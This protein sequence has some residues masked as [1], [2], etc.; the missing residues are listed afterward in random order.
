MKLS[1][2]PVERYFE[3]TAL[4]AIPVG[5]LVGAVFGFYAAGLGAAA[6]CVLLGALA[7]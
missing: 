5:A 1:E 6:L 4:W 7:A 3:L 2:N